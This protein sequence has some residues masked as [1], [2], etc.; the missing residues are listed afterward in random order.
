M[1]ANPARE[2][3]T[4]TWIHSRQPEVVWCVRTVHASRQ[5]STKT[6]PYPAAGRALRGESVACDS[7]PSSLEP[8]CRFD[9]ILAKIGQCRAWSPGHLVLWPSPLTRLKEG[10]TRNL[11]IRW[12][13]RQPRPRVQGSD[14]WYAHRRMGLLIIDDDIT[15]GGRL[16]EKALCRISSR[17][18][19]SI[20][21]LHHHLHHRHHTIATTTWRARL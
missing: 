13:P 20:L 1:T 3:N 19:L 9:E 5:N 18:Q 7:G 21:Y 15:V 16:A 10:P 14:P 6:L 17:R 2:P 12:Q 4:G 11:P 8:R